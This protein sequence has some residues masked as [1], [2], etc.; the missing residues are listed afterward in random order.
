MRKGSIA[1]HYFDLVS[2][3][4]FAAFAV[5]AWH[6]WQSSIPPS[7]I[8]FSSLAHRELIMPSVHNVSVKKGD[9]VLLV[10]T[11]KGIFMLRSSGARKRWEVG[12]PY[13]VGSP[14]YAAAFDQRQGRQRIWWGQQSARWGTTLQSTD[15]FFKTVTEPET[16]TIKFP[17]ESGLALKNIWQISLG[18]PDEPDTL[19]CGVEPVALFKSNDAGASWSPVKGL[20]DHPHR[21]QWTPGGGGLCLHTILPDPVDR[22]RMIIAMSTGGAYRTNDGGDTWQARNVG[23]RAEFLPE[24][25]PEFGQCVHKIVQHPAQPQRLYLQNH[26]GLYR[27][28]DGGDSWHDIAKGVPSDFGFCMVGHPHDP[29]TVFI[30]PIESDEYRCTPEGKLRVYRTRNGGGNW[31]PLT[32]GLPQKNALETI[33]RDSLA[34]DTADPAGIYFG[35]RSGKVYGSADEGKSW[36][37]IQEGLPSV[38]CVR[39]AVVGDAPGAG[40]QHVAAPAK[41]SS[42]TSPVRRSASRPAAR[43]RVRTARRTAS[44]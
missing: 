15:N 9:V 7:T 14:V 24:K 26:W 3:A 2:F 40:K 4:T 16:Y 34:A 8:T 31:E 22:N 44:R 11:M 27:S 30:V 10:G 23:V 41:R 35:T 43:G 18:H 6:F 12:G 29:E 33:L 36:Q 5:S 28:D 17:A 1:L 39:A 21:P 32:R 25:Y 37:L 19:Y 13:S 38:V 20:L 42:R